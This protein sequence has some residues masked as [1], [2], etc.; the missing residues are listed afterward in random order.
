M[1]IRKYYASIAENYDQNR[2]GNSYGKFIHARESA[3]LNRFLPKNALKT[4]DLGCGTGRLTHFATDAMDQ[5]AEMVAIA[6]A[7]N[8]TKNVQI[9][10]ALATNFSE[11]MFDS[12]FCFHVVMH[13]PETEV[14]QLF[15]E[16][17]RILQP[18]GV[19]IVDFPSKKRRKLLG[20]GGST[21]PDSAWHGATAFDE[22]SLQNLIGAGWKITRS[23][24]LLMW[25]IQRFPAVVRPF[26]EKIDAFSGRFF[27][28]S[29]ASYQ[30]VCLEKI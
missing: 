30:V 24:G 8:L 18:N 1:E 14:A 15:A 16:A 4:L 5:S 22:K 2:F 20:W 29:W 26:F 12:V 13:L 6:Q 17:H 27:G 7:K 10:D 3:I 9:G 25:P 19:F 28:K 21:K 23:E 11:K